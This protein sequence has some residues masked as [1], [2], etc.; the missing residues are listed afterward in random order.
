MGENQ[1]HLALFGFFFF[2]LTLQQDINHFP[3]WKK[4]H[5]EKLPFGFI[6]IKISHYKI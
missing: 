3:P 2:S 6:L 4:K 1:T 5:N